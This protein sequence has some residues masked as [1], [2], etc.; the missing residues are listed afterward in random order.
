MDK[1][2]STLLGMR[3]LGMQS[4]Y[5]V[6]GVADAFAPFPYPP[7]VALFTMSSFKYMPMDA[8]FYEF[9]LLHINLGGNDDSQPL[10]CFIE[11]FRRDQ[12]PQYIALS[13]TWGDP[14]FKKV[15]LLNGCLVSITGNLEAALRDLQQEDETEYVWADAICINQSDQEEKTVQVKCMTD[16]YRNATKVVGW[17]GHFANNA[18][19][20]IDILSLIGG[21]CSRRGGPEM[22]KKHGLALRRGDTIQASAAWSEVNRVFS[23]VEVVLAETEFPLAAFVDLTNRPYWTR[24]WILQEISI[25]IELHF[26]CGRAQ[27]PF[28][29]ISGLFVFYWLWNRKRLAKIEETQHA[30]ETDLFM[31]QHRPGMGFTSMLGSRNKFQE[32]SSKEHETLLQLCIRANVQ[33]DPAIP[34]QTSEP[35]DRIF[36][37]LGV[38]KDA[39]ELGLRPDYEKPIEDVYTQAAGA[40]LTHGCIEILTFCQFPKLGVDLPSWVPDWRGPVRRPCG[41]YK[42]ISKFAAAGDSVQL[43]QL[44]GLDHTIIRIQGI[45][46]DT[47]QSIG[48]LWNPEVKIDSSGNYIFDYDAAATLFSEVRAFVQESHNLGFWPRCTDFQREEAIWRIPIADQEQDTSIGRNRRATALSRQGFNDVTRGIE[49]EAEE[50]EKW[51]EGKSSYINMMGYLHNRRPFLSKKGY[52][53]LGPGGLREGD[54]IYVLLGAYVPFILRASQDSVD[55]ELIGEAYVHGIMDGELMQQDLAIETILL[56]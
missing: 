22:M 52:V 54:L 39:I 2:G 36:A 43:G 16:I 40:W 12:C 25:P 50:R 13:Y 56:R 44:D 3:Q 51:S 47:I 10:A 23:E 33:A 45:R 30:T 41:E 15:I 24:L 26:A 46:V 19:D 4:R 14:T 8:P 9:R 11:H 55:H 29:S 5:E 1:Q 21:E 34:L 18:K 49:F 7:S 17:L 35:R 32:N 53:G 38:A 37:L 27:F 48:H 42:E 20:A 28:T 6:S 31:L